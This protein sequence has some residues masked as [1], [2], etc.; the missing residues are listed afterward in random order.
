MSPRP[1]VPRH[2]P[3]C[4]RDE[5][6]ERFG[7]RTCGQDLWHPVERVGGAEIRERP[8]H[9]L[10][11]LGREESMFQVVQRSTVAARAQLDQDRL[12]QT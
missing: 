8:E 12:D 5:C 4:V 9:L 6:L 10:G 7:G 3:V 2:A 1:L 11:L